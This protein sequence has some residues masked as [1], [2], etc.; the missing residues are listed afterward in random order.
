LRLS[1]QNR[2][3]WPLICALSLLTQRSFAADERNELIQEVF[4][5]ELVY[6]QNAGETQLRLSPMFQ[7]EPDARTLTLTTAIEYGLSDQ[8]QIGAEWDA[9]VYRKPDHARSA[10]GI[11]DTELSLKYGFGD[12]SD[13]DIHAAVQ[14][15]LGLPTGDARRQLGEGLFIFEPSLMFAK[16]FPHWANLQLFTQ[17]GLAFIQRESGHDAEPA[18][19]EFVWNNGLFLPLGGF[20]WSAEFNWS[21]NEWNHGGKN[22]EFYFTPGWTWSPAA[23]WELGAGVPIGL[24]SSSDD[25]RVILKIIREF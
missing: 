5:T 20:V 22:N 21:N 9:W 12:F 18:A 2:N 7:R 3:A 1:F 24:N 8:W 25:F 17:I 13:R 11:G 16:D 19:H 4:Q 10:S 23:G 15:D 14:F 6:S